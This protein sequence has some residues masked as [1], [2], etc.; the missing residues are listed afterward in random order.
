MVKLT[1]FVFL[2]KIIIII[3]II[4]L[5]QITFMNYLILTLKQL[6]FSTIL[7]PLFLPDIYFRVY[8]AFTFLYAS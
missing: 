7:A 1:K 4:I 3:I 8:L 6:W 2:L 5:N